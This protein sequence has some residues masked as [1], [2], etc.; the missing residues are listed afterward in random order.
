MGENFLKLLFRSLYVLF[1]QIRRKK[2]PAFYQDS[3]NEDLD[4]HMAIVTLKPLFHRGQECIGIYFEKNYSLQKIIRTLKG[5]KWSQTNK[6]W[7][8]SCLREHFENLKKILPANS[9]L[10]T[11][12]LKTYLEQRKTIADPSKPLKA[13]S[14]QII[15]T[16]ILSDENLKAFEAMKNILV[17]KGYSRNTM[18]IYCNEFH[19]L[20]RLLG[21]RSINSL[22]KSHILSY[23]LWL[24]KKKKY[25]EQHV[26]S[27]VNAIK[28][29]FEKVMKYPP[30]F[31]D[32]PRPKKPQ[33]LPTVL[34]GEEIITLIK[35][36]DNIKHKTMIMTGYAGG[37]RVSEIVHLK[38]T[39][40]DSKRMTIHLRCA[41]GKKDRMVPLSK[42]LLAQLRIYVTQ[43]KPKE[44]LF[45][46]QGG[47]QYSTRSAQQVLQDAKKAAG[48][49][50]SGS[51]HSLRHS[52]A[53][54]LLESGTDIRYI[55]DLLGHNTIKTTMR[56]THV[57][58]KVIGNIQSPLDKLDW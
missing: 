18:R 21:A 32:L 49:T 42:K 46:G 51:M 11:K 5:I 14:Y 22:E 37:L 44:F 12:E 40:I 43:Y 48:I 34:A 31:Y 55:Q 29:Y 9:I 56:Y 58:N 10:E 35:K 25:S 36:I 4:W 3:P 33:K 57:S 50:K 20:L 26:H 15:T 8:M 16:H 52:Y 13:I 30:E 53:T 23:L 6:C 1:F 28:F 47:G 54:H 41:K 2:Q 19:H 27:T 7:Y 45:E 17:L 38:I 24:I 39:D